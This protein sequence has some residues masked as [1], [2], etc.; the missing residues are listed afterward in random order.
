MLSI[1]LCITCHVY[2]LY[3]EVSVHIS[4]SFL[5]IGFFLLKIIKLIKIYSTQKAFVRQLFYKYFVPDCGLPFHS[6]NSV[7]CFLLCGNQSCGWP[8]WVL[9][10]CSLKRGLTERWSLSR[11]LRFQ[12]TFDQP[13]CSQS[14]A[15]TLCI[16]GCILGL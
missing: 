13:R 15:Y 3:S 10:N 11:H 1:Y 6:Y 14:E 7:F 12:I 2:L 4:C 8:M 9:K 5:K 16:W